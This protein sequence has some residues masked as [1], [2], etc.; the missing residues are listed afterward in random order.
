MENFIIKK[1]SIVFLF[2][3]GAVLPEQF[4]VISI[5][6]PNSSL[7]D[8]LS[9]TYFKV[10]PKEDKSKNAKPANANSLIALTFDDGP[11]KETTSEI[12]DELEKNDAH[13]TFFV[14]G[15]QAKQCPDILKRQ[16]AN[17]HEIGNHTFSHS[18]LTKLNVKNIKS[19]IE[20]T[21]KIVEKATDQ[22]PKLVRA[23]GGST[24]EQVKNIVNKPFIHWSVDPKDWKTRDT[25][26]TIELVLKN[27]ADGD[28]VLMHDIYPATVQ[29]VKKIV[30]E[31][32]NRGFSLVTVSEMFNIKDIPLE[33]KQQY[34]KA[35]N[36]S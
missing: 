6:L 22:L 14:V 31:L 16:I 13:A 12:L 21:E 27:A 33:A 32:I 24:N 7:K 25:Q 26:Q 23:P 4:G 35:A 10:N 15:K 19:E 29:A 17:G 30:P 3:S 34:T 1:D 5:E 36:P 18:T 9:K 11:N 28:I 8:S 2:N 20:K